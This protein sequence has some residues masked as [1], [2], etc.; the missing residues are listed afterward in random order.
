MDSP[1]P[2]FDLDQRLGARLKAA[3]LRRELTLDTLAE[4]TGVSRAMISRIERG[5][6]SPTAALLVKLCAGL[7][8]SLSSLF[9]AEN[10]AGPIARRVEQPVWQDPD[11]GYVRRNVSPPGTGSAIEIVEVTTPP[12]ARVRLGRPWSRRGLDQQVWVF[13]GEIELT[14]DEAT[15]RLQAGDCMHMRLDGP[16]TYHNPGHE[17]VRYAVVLTTIEG[18]N[19]ERPQ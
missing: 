5:E 6:S 12:G 4:R 14:I 10:Q 18:S 17:P 16:I 9:S 2:D 7:D 8:L 15:H 19:P 3:R 11:S 13:E 1:R